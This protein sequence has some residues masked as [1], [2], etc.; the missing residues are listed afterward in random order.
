MN[1]ENP[2]FLL[3]YER[4]G[5]ESDTFRRPSYKE[6]FHTKKAKQIIQQVVS[7][8]LDQAIYDKDQAP[9]WANEIAEE[10]KNKLLEMELSRY[11][12]IVNVTILENKGAGARIQVNGLWDS[13]SDSYAQEIFKNKNE[14]II[15]VVLAFGVYFY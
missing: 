7:G 9:G 14:T 15:C 12:Y 13:S 10:I 4:R 5:S 3:D 2:E 8:K 6:K 11:K 1:F